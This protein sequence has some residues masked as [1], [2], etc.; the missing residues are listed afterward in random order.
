VQ[1]QKI[2]QARACLA[3]VERVEN[4]LATRLDAAVQAAI[5]LDKA[6][7]RDLVIQDC[8]A[9]KYDEPPEHFDLRWCHAYALAPANALLSK[10]EAGKC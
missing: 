4:S 7:R 2:A 6:A 5:Y 1:A 3:D 9:C 10:W 8:I